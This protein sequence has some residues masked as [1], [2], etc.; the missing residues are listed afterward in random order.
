MLT[1]DWGETR[2]EWSAWSV[3]K[4]GGGQDGVWDRY[5]VHDGER[6]IMTIEVH[7]RYLWISGTCVAQCADL[8]L[9]E[10]V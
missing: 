3:V 2:P 7:G 6:E 10:S 1:R 9:M 8:G 4:D 5:G